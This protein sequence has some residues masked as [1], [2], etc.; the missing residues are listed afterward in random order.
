VADLDHVAVSQGMA[1]DR[2]AIGL[3]E[4]KDLFVP[5]FK[6]KRP[7]IGLAVESGGTPKARSRL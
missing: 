5:F 7:A 2:F 4:S 6:K 1:L 3:P